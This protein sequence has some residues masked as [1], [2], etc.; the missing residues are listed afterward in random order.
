[1]S[2]E[3]GLWKSQQLVDT[4]MKM[5]ATNVDPQPVRRSLRTVGPLREIGVDGFEISSTCG[6]RWV[7]SNVSKKC[8]NKG[9]DPSLEKKKSSLTPFYKTNSL[10]YNPLLR[11]IPSY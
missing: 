10:L 2:R 8:I 3:S 5:E 11:F 9:V 7:A 6:G 1:M 4:V